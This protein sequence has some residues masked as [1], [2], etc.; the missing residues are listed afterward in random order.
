MSDHS[1]PAGNLE[2][3]HHHVRI[4]SRPWGYVERTNDVDGTG[5]N[6]RLR[7]FSGRPDH[8]DGSGPVGHNALDGL[9]PT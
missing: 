5:G 7:M 9:E 8:D 6:G 1:N 4:F 3:T 2:V